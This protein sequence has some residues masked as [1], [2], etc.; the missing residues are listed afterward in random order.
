MAHALGEQPLERRHPCLF[1]ETP[2]EVR[3]LMV[4]CRA[5]SDSVN[6]SPRWS[7]SHR[8]VGS[9][10]PLVLLLTRLGWLAGKLTRPPV[11]PDVE[12]SA[13]PPLTR[14]CAGPAQRSPQDSVIP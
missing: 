3:G 7:R 4:A 14:T 5:M 13:T 6:G 8:M 11:P 1:G 9:S 2:V 12:G 10:E